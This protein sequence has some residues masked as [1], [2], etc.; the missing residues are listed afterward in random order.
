M[1]EK[2]RNP[3]P[4]FLYQTL[5]DNHVLAGY[6]IHNV[7]A[8]DA[9]ETT[10]L[11]LK[12][13]ERCVIREFF[14]VGAATRQTDFA[15]VAEGDAG[16]DILRR[17]LA[18][19][20]HQANRLAGIRHPCI[21][22]VI[23]FI[24]ANNTGY[25]VSRVVEG[26][27]LEA[28]LSG[29]PV[30]DEARLIEFFTPLLEGLGLVHAA[31]LIHGELDLECIRVKPDGIPVLLGCSSGRWRLAGFPGCPGVIRPSAYAAIEQILNPTGLQPNP[32]AD[33]Y[34]LAAI[35]YL[36]AFGANPPDAL[37]RYTATQPGALPLAVLAGQD[38]FSPHFLH[39]IDWGLCVQA[40]N[41]PKDAATWRAVIHGEKPLPPHLLQALPITQDRSSP[42]RRGKGLVKMMLLLIILGILAGASYYYFPQLQAWFEAWKALSFGSP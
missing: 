11:A 33:I 7:L 30:S 31:G 38:R 29:N 35:I 14:P 17:G 24:E 10:Y 26:N 3:S 13:G 15:L 1:G 19:F 6:T 39:A 8:Q 9:Y 32:T 40:E 28:Y 34:A 25:I 36:A 16:R 5:P 27:T 42:R 22:E 23:E 37:A 12:D 18:D 21:E 4:V 20:R 41:R 2:M